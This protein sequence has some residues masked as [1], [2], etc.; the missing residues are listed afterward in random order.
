MATHGK[1]AG[2]ARNNPQVQ[3][4]A[5]HLSSQRCSLLI[6][7]FL[8]ADYSCCAYSA[9]KTARLSEAAC[10]MRKSTR[11]HG[12]GDSLLSIQ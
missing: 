1:A 9:C 8:S 6:G 3:T 7:G 10:N 4:D 12:G 11:P 5:P 2:F